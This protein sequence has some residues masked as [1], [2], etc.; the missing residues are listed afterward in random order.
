MKGGDSLA[1]LIKILSYNNDI[2]WVL[3]KYGVYIIL[4]LYV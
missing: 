4:K 1:Q 3:L 2:L